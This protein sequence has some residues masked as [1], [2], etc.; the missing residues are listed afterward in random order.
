MPPKKK[1][2]KT[3]A[4]DPSSGDEL[5]SLTNR[6][7]AEIVGFFDDSIPPSLYGLWRRDVVQLI[8]ESEVLEPQKAG[9]DRWS[10]LHHHAAGLPII[11]P[12]GMINYAADSKVLHVV[13]MLCQDIAKK[14][15]NGEAARTRARK[16][17]RTAHAASYPEDPSPPALAEDA[18]P[19]HLTKQIVLSTTTKTTKAATTG[20]GTGAD[21]SLLAQLYK[22]LGG[23]WALA[24]VYCLY[25]A[26]AQGGNEP[27]TAMM[28]MICPQLDNRNTLPYLAGF[29]FA[30]FGC[31]W[32]RS[33]MVTVQTHTKAALKQA[34]ANWKPVGREIVAY[35][36]TRT[37]T[38]GTRV[39][40]E[41]V[42]DEDV[43]NLFG[44]HKKEY[45]IDMQCE[46][47]PPESDTEGSHSSDQSALPVT[48]N[49]R[50][51][52][53]GAPPTKKKTQQD[54]GKKKA[55]E[56][57]K[58]KAVD[59]GVGEKSKG[60]VR[61]TGTPS[62]PAAKASSEAGP[63]GHNTRLTRST[64]K[65]RPPKRTSYRVAKSGLQYGG[66]S[67]MEEWDPSI[68]KEEEEEEKKDGGTPK[69]M[70]PMSP[71]Y[72]GPS[73][74]EKRDPNEEKSLDPDV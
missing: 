3:P 45:L 51:K 25:G 22:Q 26:P 48:L 24:V 12:R 52:S 39:Y 11:A 28:H 54:K 27:N 42:M 40:K 56:K 14:V 1:A 35:W 9:M 38:N 63:S 31:K 8:T 44:H 43:H 46:M 53:G 47:A 16:A 33:K 66:P 49:K 67:D 19:L 60:Q 71:E 72:G 74:V 5:I 68:E 64:S 70:P 15:R 21:A 50:T 62:V 34:A 36:G 20:A 59:K 37:R 41:L 57:G 6:R 58:G 13:N 65:G 18:P 32:Q 30:A 61:G 29:T 73:D 7:Y 10:I 17:A 2:T 4:N 55:V 23:L 69:P